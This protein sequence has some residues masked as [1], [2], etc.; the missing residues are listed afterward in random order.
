MLCK[1]VW[2]KNGVWNDGNVYEGYISELGFCEF[3]VDQGSYIGKSD[4]TMTECRDKCDTALGCVTTD[5]ISGQDTDFEGGPGGWT[6]YDRE[7]GNP[8]DNCVTQNG[9]ESSS[10]HIHA[11]CLSTQGGIT[12]TFPTTNGLSYKLTFLAQAGE[13]DGVDTDVVYVMIENSSET[14]WIQFSV[15]PGGWE[16]IGVAFTAYGD[17]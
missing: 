16:N 2:N 15:E 5:L 14:H 13:W 3:D 7:N 11:M 12:Q 6:C 8:H 17:R 1:D 10:M 9:Y 4:V